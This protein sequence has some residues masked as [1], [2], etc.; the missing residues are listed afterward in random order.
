[1]G[2]TYLFNFIESH[3]RL[4]GFDLYLG[5]YHKQFYERKSLVCDLVEPFRCIID[6]SIRKAYGLKQIDAA[7]FFISNGQYILKYKK[8]E[9]YNHIFIG[10]IMEFREE[11]FKYIQQ[12][13]RSFIQSKAITEFPFFEI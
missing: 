8:N 2:Y 3:L 6:K 1:M 7:D 5:I 9:K 4:Y 11:I 12:Y 13:Y 10:S